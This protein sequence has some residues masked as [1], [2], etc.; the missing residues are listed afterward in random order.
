MPEV[1]IRASDGS[2]RTIAIPVSAGGT[3]LQP[4]ANLTNAYNAAAAGATLRL[5]AGNWG[6]V[7]TP[8]G[9]KAVTFLAE[10]GAVFG[11]ISFRTSNSVWNGGVARE[12]GITGCSNSTVRN[13][14]VDGNGGTFVT[15][16]MAN[17]TNVLVQ[18]CQIGN[19]LN[20][21]GVLLDVANENP[22]FHRVT[23]HDVR[24][25]DPNVHNEGMYVNHTRGLSL[26]DCRFERCATMD[27]FVTNSGSGVVAERFNFLGNFFGRTFK[28]D[29]T[30]HFFTIG[31]H[32]A[33]GSIR[34]LTARDNVLELSVNRNGLS[35]TG[36]ESRNSIPFNIPG[37]TQQ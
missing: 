12:V 18:D 13:L 21:K 35:G 28:A 24:V 27:V 32:N 11:D 33:L 37:V 29:G 8:T 20:E 10:P 25:N 2:S 5:A 23:V 14:E 30:S 17:T 31:F 15:L 9:T 1:H 4:G 19:I 16:Y 22:T 3:V 26:L 7:Q 36:V 34:Q 6:N